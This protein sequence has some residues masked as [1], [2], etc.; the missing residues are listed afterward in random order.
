MK[1]SRGRKPGGPRTK[2]IGARATGIEPVF[3]QW[4]CALEANVQD[5]RHAVRSADRLRASSWLPKGEDR[6]RM[7]HALVS[8]LGRLQGRDDRRGRRSSRRRWGDHSRVSTSAGQ[9]RELVERRKR[10]AASL[11]TKTGPYTASRPS[12][13]ILYGW[14]A[15]GS[16]LRTRATAWRGSSFLYSAR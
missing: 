5:A 10:E 7:G 1:S 13:S 3:P 2:H 14:S 11:P 9:A 6:R 15:V 8:R 12:S 4:R 16:L